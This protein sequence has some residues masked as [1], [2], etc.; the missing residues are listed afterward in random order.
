MTAPQRIETRIQQRIIEAWLHNRHLDWKFERFMVATFY[1]VPLI[2]AALALWRIGNG[3]INLG[4][5][6]FTINSALIALFVWGDSN[7]Y[8]KRSL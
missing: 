6:G 4:L 3:S 7:T 1:A 2:F 8:R 5:L